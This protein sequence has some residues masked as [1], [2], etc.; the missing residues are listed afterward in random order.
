[1]PRVSRRGQVRCLCG[2]DA[3]SGRRA[4]CQATSDAASVL[5]IETALAKATLPREDLRDPYKTLHKMTVAELSAADPVIDWP[6][7]FA[8]QGSPGLTKLNVEQPQFQKAVDAELTSEPLAALKAYLRFH[9][10]QGAASLLSTPFVTADF[11]FYRGYLRGAK[12]QRPRW[13]HCV[14]A[15]DDQLGEALGQEFVRRTFTPETKQ[16]RFR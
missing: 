5:R 16:R 6:A 10:V 13:K 1:M 8:A 14:A 9:T 15:V 11:D 4:L 2:A 12:Q 7:Y 3:D